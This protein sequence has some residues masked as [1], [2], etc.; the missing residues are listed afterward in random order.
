MSGGR[1]IHLVGFIDDGNAFFKC[2]RRKVETVEKYEQVAQTLV[3]GAAV[4]AVALQKSHIDTEFS[5][6]VDPE[7]STPLVGY[8]IRF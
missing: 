1:L 5:L 3:I 4:I 7:T 2:N 8:K 6:T